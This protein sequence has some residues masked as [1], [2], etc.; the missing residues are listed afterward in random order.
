MSSRHSSRSSSRQSQSRPSS[1]LEGL[2]TN[3]AQRVQ[4]LRVGDLGGPGDDP[5]KNLRWGT[6]HAKVRTEQ[7]VS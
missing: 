2:L 3:L 6:A 7:K 4:T 5:P 1:A